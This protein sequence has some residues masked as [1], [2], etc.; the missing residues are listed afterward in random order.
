LVS[1]AGTT[2]PTDLWVPS[3]FRVQPQISW[4]YAGGVFKNFKNNEYETS[5]E[6]Y[7]KRMQ[8]QIEYREGYSPSLR[9]PEEEF[10]FGKG[11]SYGSELFVNKTRG[12]L[13]GWIGY[14]LSWTWR[15]FPDL[16]SGVKYP[17]KYDRR[18]DL[19]VV[20]TY[21]LNSKWKLGGVFIY[22]TGNA[23][24]LP[25]RF[26]VVNGVLTQEYSAINKYRLPSYH[27][28]DIS[29]T[30][31]PQKKNKKFQSYWVFSVYNAYNRKNPYF[32]Y[33]DQSGSP[34]NGTLEIQAK[35]VSLFPVLPSVTWNFSLN[36]P[37]QLSWR[38]L[39]VRP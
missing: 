12:R 16:N 5:I 31:T 18:H 33:F 6:V 9:D 8:N 29:A 15:K 19:S 22:A 28:F 24:S 10:V 11:W 17:A 36:L 27:R 34:Y 7:Y 26:Y 20:G 2:L 32:I 35:Q 4:Q 3:T 1:N 25:E 13:T 38:G 23:T 21:E 30:Y 14:T 39:E 37:L